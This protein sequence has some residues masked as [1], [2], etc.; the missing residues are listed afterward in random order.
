MALRTF[1]YI[2][3]VLPYSHRQCPYDESHILHYIAWALEE[4]HNT[5]GRAGYKS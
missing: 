2:G 1:F 5:F 3:Y 4:I